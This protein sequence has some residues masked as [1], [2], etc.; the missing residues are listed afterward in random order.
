[1]EDLIFTQGNSGAVVQKYTG[2]GSQLTIPDTWNG[3]PVTETCTA[4]AA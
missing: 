2:H 4:F 1:M 3:N